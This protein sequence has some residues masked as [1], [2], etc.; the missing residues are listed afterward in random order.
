MAAA[1]SSIAVG[2]LQLAGAK[3]SQLVQWQQ[4]QLVQLCPTKYYNNPG[5]WL[6]TF[7]SLVR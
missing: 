2:P 1:L 5:F 3:V 4:L 7:S 6:E